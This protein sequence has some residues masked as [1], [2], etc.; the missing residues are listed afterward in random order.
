MTTYIIQAMTPD[1]HFNYMTGSNNYGVETLRIEAMSAEAAALA[2]ENCGY[3]VNRNN[4]KTADE[5]EAEVR[6]RA[7]RRRAA[8]EAEAK[9]KARK[10]ENEARKAA[11]AGMT[12][13]EYKAEKSRRAAIRRAERDLERAEA[14]VERLK[15]YIEGLKR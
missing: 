13:A 9:A 4:I 15:A 10:A 14:E 11:E 7:E 3:V 12:V 8:D 1:D 6:E 5:V 2:V